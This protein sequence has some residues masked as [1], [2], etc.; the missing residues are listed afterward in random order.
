M[1]VVRTLGILAV[2]SFATLAFGQEKQPTTTN[3]VA[4]QTQQIDQGS[5]FIRNV[6]N[7]G[8]INQSLMKGLIQTLVPKTEP[9]GARACTPGGNCGISS[10]FCCICGGFGRCLTAQQCAQTCG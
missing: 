6:E 7:N 4:T 8:L 3:A 9:N 10:L 1:N 5:Q 2:L